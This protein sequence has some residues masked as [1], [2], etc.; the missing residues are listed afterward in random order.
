MNCSTDDNNSK[1]S[2]NTTTYS[3]I[4]TESLTMINDNDD[5]DHDNHFI[6]KSGL[7]TI[8]IKRQLW[9]IPFINGIM[10]VIACVIPYIVTVLKGLIY[11]IWPMVSDAGAILPAASYFS[12]FLDIIAALTAFVGIILY[13]QIHYYRCELNQRLPL[14]SKH[15]NDD[16]YKNID[17]LK[18]CNRI[19]IIMTI[20]M[21]TGLVLTGNFRST[22]NLTGHMIGVTLFLPSGLLFGCALIYVYEI[23]YSHGIQSKPITT[24]IIIMIG[25][26]FTIGCGIFTISSVLKY[27]SIWD[28]W[29]NEL[30]LHWKPMMPGYWLHTMGNVCEW[31]ALLSFGPLNIIISRR[32]RLFQYWN[33]IKL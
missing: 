31:I 22:E 19:I 2:N 13:K 6:Q 7:L 25:I 14:G 26:V 8:N 33:C 27:G 12:T 9:L 17:H 5:H 18:L 23:L 32:F 30:R 10:I 28:M 16:E 11:P 3:I 4:T 20:F 29:N 24:T 1:K 21:S 15:N